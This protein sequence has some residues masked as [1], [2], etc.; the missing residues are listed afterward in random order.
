MFV[1]FWQERYDSLD[2][3]VDSDG[4]GVAVSNDI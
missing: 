4:G 2:L 1:F 3:D